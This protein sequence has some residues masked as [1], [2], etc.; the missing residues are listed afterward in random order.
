M[1]KAP[2]TMR[3]L[4]Q[5]LNRKLKPEYRRFCVCVAAIA[6]ARVISATSMS[7]T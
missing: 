3:A 2:I 7:S 5:R 4:I 1:D 6:G